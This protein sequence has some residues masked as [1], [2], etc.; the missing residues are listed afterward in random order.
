[1]GSHV[2]EGS[3]STG[4]AKSG[5]GQGLRWERQPEMGADLNTGGKIRG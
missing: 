1:M 4:A 2:A 3:G 5:A